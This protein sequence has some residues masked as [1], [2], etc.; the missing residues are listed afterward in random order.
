MA[1]YLHRV[2]AMRSVW[3]ALL[4]LAACTVEQKEEL[5]EESLDDPERRTE[6]TEAVLR[7]MDENPEYVD[8]FF[9]LARRHPETFDRALANTARH[10]TDPKLAARVAAQLV[11]HPAGLQNVIVQTLDAAKAPEPRAAIA[12]AIETRAN[13]AAEILV[14]HP[15][16]L[17]TIGRAILQQAM[18]DPAAKAR[19]KKLVKEHVK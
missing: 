16:Q 6:M 19:M 18:A 15:E 14:E 12:E 11:E 1:R 9:R 13:R 2:A 17:A 3:I 4:A 5:A 10:L 8:E 7:V